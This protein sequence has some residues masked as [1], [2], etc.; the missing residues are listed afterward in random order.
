MVDLSIDL[1]CSE[2]LCYS[3]IIRGFYI[4]QNRK[5]ICNLHLLRN[6]LV[7]ILHIEIDFL[8]VVCSVLPEV[9]T[10]MAGLHSV[11]LLISLFI[12]RSVSTPMVLCKL[13]GGGC[14]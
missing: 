11:S 10:S 3:V 8:K 6:I 1:V 14:L 12:Y 7:T 4:E 2:H 13:L 5:Y 9:Y